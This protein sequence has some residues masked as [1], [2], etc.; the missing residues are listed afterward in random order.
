[1]KASITATL[2]AACLLGTA[3][4]PAPAHAVTT[5]M[6]CSSARMK[7]VINGPQN[8][9]V[10]NFPVFNNATKFGCGTGTSYTVQ[11]ISALGYTIVQAGNTVVRL[12]Q[13][14]RANGSFTHTTY[15]QFQLVI[16]K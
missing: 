10:Q 16:Q 13:L 2:A 1:M 9:H 5:G 12:E 8:P 7:V 6:V 11:Q 4:M 14:T 3:M 15:H